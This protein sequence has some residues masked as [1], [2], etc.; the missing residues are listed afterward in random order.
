MEVDE[1][2]KVEIEEELL[3]GLLGLGWQDLDRLVEHIY[4]YDVGVD[5]VLE[6][7]EECLASGLDKNDPFRSIGGCV[8]IGTVDAVRNRIL[9]KVD[10]YF[11]EETA[12]I[13]RHAVENEWEEGDLYYISNIEPIANFDGD[14]EKL[15]KELKDWAYN[16][17]VK[18]AFTP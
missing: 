8:I 5:K 18:E 6:Y 11:D 15:M 16:V 1:K 12:E 10:E 3:R 17:V 9:D 2:K 13:I 14:W 4:T 7:A